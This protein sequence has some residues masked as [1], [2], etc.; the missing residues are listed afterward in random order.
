LNCVFH[1]VHVREFQS[2]H[3]RKERMKEKGLIILNVIDNIKWKLGVLQLHSAYTRATTDPHADVQG[4]EDGNMTQR[5][6]RQLHES[7]ESFRMGG[8]FK[9]TPRHCA[10]K[11]CS[12]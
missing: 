4:V 10:D 1:H 9:C 2:F 8:K 5:L 7:E 11:T 6:R 12:R 3:K